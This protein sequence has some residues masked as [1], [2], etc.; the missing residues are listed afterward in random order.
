M[1]EYVYSNAPA[2]L[3]EIGDG[4]VFVS[5]ITRTY[6]IRTGELE[7]RCVDESGRYRVD[8]DLHGASTVDDA[9]PRVLLRRTRARQERA[10]HDD[11]ELHRPRGRRRRVG[12]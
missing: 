1:F 2:G 12:A 4:R 7:E 6:T 5:P 11:D 9:R 8:A 10:Q 3:G